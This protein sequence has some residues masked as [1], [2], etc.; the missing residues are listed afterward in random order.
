MFRGRRPRTPKCRPTPG[1]SSRSRPISPNACASSS[2]SVPT[3]ARLPVGSLYIGGGNRYGSEP[4][5]NQPYFGASYVTGPHGPVPFVPAP[6][7]LVVADLD[8]DAL[9]GPDPSGWDFSRDRRPDI[10]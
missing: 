9:H 8:F 6:R 5:W 3:R 2:P 10:Y 7:G 1:A 4:P